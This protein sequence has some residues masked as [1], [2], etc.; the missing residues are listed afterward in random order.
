MLTRPVSKASLLDLQCHL[1]S[2]L[3]NVDSVRNSH[4][5]IKLGMCLE[6]TGRLGYHERKCLQNAVILLMSLSDSSGNGVL[7]FIVFFI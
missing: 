2:G 5:G 1:Q 4:M 7:G 6:F 3:K